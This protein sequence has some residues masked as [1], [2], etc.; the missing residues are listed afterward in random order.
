MD[1]VECVISATKNIDVKTSRTCCHICSETGYNGSKGIWAAM[2]GTSISWSK[3]R[4]AADRHVRPLAGVHGFPRAAVSIF[5][6]LIL[7]LSAAASARHEAQA[8]AANNELTQLRLLF[9]G[10]AEAPENL[11]CHHNDDGSSGVPGRDQ[12]PLCRSCCVLCLG[13]H[14]QPVLVPPGSAFVPATSWTAILRPRPS[15]EEFA[16]RLHAA[17]QARPRAPPEA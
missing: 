3:G 17:N 11:I 16:P 5:A 8:A 13:L 15:R 14:H 6:S 12:L 10:Q 7:L 4:G 2:V 9:D 1:R